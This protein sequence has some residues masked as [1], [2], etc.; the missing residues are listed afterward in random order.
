LSKLPALGQG[1]V[2]DCAGGIPVSPLGDL[3]EQPKRL[4]VGCE[5]RFGHSRMTSSQH[6]ASKPKVAKVFRSS[7]MTAI[8][9][10]GCS[11]VSMARW[12]CVPVAVAPMRAAILSQNAC[13][14]P[15]IPRQPARP[16][17][18]FSGALWVGRLPQTARMTPPRGSKPARKLTLEF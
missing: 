18:G 12:L 4:N 13:Q 16:G 15:A 9:L 5:Q 14:S 6:C 1:Q 17:I 7:P 11:T 10:P 3:A 8:P 2:S